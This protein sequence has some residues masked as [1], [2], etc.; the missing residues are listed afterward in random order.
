MPIVLS[1]RNIGTDV[2]SSPESATSARSRRSALTST[3]TSTSS[4]TPSPLNG[5]TLPQ[6]AGVI[7]GV[8]GAI[9]L[10]GLLWYYCVWRRRGG[11]FPSPP[12][13]LHSYTKSPR[14]PSNSSSA[15]SSTTLLRPPPGPLPG[16]SPRQ[17]GPPAP[18]D[19]PAVQHEF[20]KPRSAPSNSVQQAPLIAQ[21]GERPPEHPASPAVLSSG[22]ARRTP[23]KTGIPGPAH[24]DGDSPTVHAAVLNP[25]PG[26]SNPPPSAALPTSAGACSNTSAARACSGLRSE[27]SH[28]GQPAAIDLLSDH[29]YRVQA[30][31]TA[32]LAPEDV[33]PHLPEPPRLARSSTLPLPAV[34]EPQSIA[35]TVAATPVAQNIYPPRPRVDF[36]L[37]STDDRPDL[38]STSNQPPDHIHLVRN[39]GATTQSVS[40]HPSYTARSAT[41][42]HLRASQFRL[43]GARRAATFAGFSDPRLQ[44][45]HPAAYVETQGQAYPA[46]PQNFLTQEQLHNQLRTRRLQ[47]AQA[48]GMGAPQLQQFYPAQA[49]Q[50]QAP[51]GVIVLRKVFNVRNQ[52]RVGT[53]SLP[54]GAGMPRRFWIKERRIRRLSRD[55]NEESGNDD[56]NEVDAGGD[57]QDGDTDEGETSSNEEAHKEVRPRT[58][59]VGPSRTRASHLQASYLQPAQLWPSRLL[60]VERYR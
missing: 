17:R 12:T 7:V 19:V 23:D 10:L 50:A 9:L 58:N 34:A 55:E 36:V 1:V 20:S 3:S 40:P 14:P 54:K 4:T 48:H 30:P 49:T 35:P 26:P 8:L 16:R 59:V 41:D 60:N 6:I 28:R 29:Q 45:R 11:A 31:P 52:E 43:P 51:P 27:A 5:L 38:Q 37:E 13:S 33:R 44:A 18:I 22:P 56:D 15:P 25:R 47:Q 42:N 39:V 32:Q 21:R 53:I 24:R 2:S 57:D 46:A